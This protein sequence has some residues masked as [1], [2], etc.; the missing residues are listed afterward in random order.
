MADAKDSIINN[1]QEI[2]LTTFGGLR[3]RRFEEVAQKLNLCWKNSHGD[4]QWKTLISDPLKGE[5]KLMSSAATTTTANTTANITTMI[6]TTCINRAVDQVSKA[7][8]ISY[9][10]Q[11]DAVDKWGLKSGNY[12]ED[13]VLKAIRDSC[14]DH[15]CLS[16]IVDL[17]DPMWRNYFF[18]RNGTR[19]KPVIKSN[20]PLYQITYKNLWIYTITA[21]FKLPATIKHLL[22]SKC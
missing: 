15:P 10:E 4:S 1:Y 6:K 11:L 18:S 21:T 9:L 2:N 19:S 7:R 16:F 5:K 8:A 14:Y 22:Q 3:K 13:T 20:F 17:A 12:V